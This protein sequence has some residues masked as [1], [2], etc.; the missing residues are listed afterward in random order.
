M[1]NN[2]TPEG[3][4]NISPIVPSSEYLK[5]EARKCEECNVFFCP[6][7]CFNAHPGSMIALGKLLRGMAKDKGEVH[8]VIER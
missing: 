7:Q 8:V 4:K 5:M 6:E 1:K 3:K 2:P